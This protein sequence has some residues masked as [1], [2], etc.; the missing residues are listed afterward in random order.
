MLAEVRYNGVRLFEL[1]ETS[2]QLY[3]S[4]S[5]FVQSASHIGSSASRRWT[6]CA[7][8]DRQRCTRNM[9]VTDQRQTLKPEQSR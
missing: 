4:A 7:A 6:Q 3:Q 8:H 1:P 9:I 2:K 5:A